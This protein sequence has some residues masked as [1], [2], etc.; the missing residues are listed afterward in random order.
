MGFKVV[1]NSGN[2]EKKQKKNSQ[3]P[4]LVFYPDSRHATH[5]LLVSPSAAPL[6]WTFEHHS[7]HTITITLKQKP[8]NPMKKYIRN[9]KDLFYR[10]SLQTTQIYTQVLLL[11]NSSAENKTRTLQLW[12]FNLFGQFFFF[13]V[14]LLA[15]Q[16]STI[17]FQN[18]TFSCAEY[19]ESLPEWISQSVHIKSFIAYNKEKKQ[20]CQRLNSGKSFSMWD[21]TNF[22]KGHQMRFKPVQSCRSWVTPQGS[23]WLKLHHLVDR[24][25]RCNRFRA[26]NPPIC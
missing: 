12:D 2:Y 4:D 7:K 24:G 3:D 26:W 19:G 6:R 23:G 10:L 25:E 17:I 1:D 22:V 9:I 15:S 20:T 13:S 21:K 8:T 11:H 16:N 18:Y 5:L 14:L